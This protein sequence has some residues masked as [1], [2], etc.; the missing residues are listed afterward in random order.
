MLVKK[1]FRIPLLAALLCFWVILSFIFVHSD[2]D[3]FKPKLS[4]LVSHA[5]AL[6]TDERSYNSV[7]SAFSGKP[8]S[9]PHDWFNQGLDTTVVWYRAKFLT[10]KTNEEP[11]AVYLP[12]VTH[13]AEIYINGT[14]IGHSS[15][16]A[17]PIPRHHNYPILLEF[18]SELLKAENEIV[19]RVE[20]AHARQGLLGEFFVAPSSQL[21]ESY[22]SKNIWR[23][24]LIKW[25]TA[26]MLF[27]AFIIL[28]F[29]L[30]RP[31]D[32]IYGL[33][34]LML[35][36]W[37]AHNLNLFVIHI[38]V[39][40]HFWESMTMATL[41][42]TVVL[43][44]HFNHR[45][46]GEPVAVIEK[47]AVI[48]AIAGLG[49]FLIP[50]LGM[51]LHFG[52]LVWDGF[53][54][55]FGIYALLYLGYKFYQKLELD[56]YLMLVA[57]IP[58]LVFGLHDILVVNHLRSRTE[59]LIIQYSVLP[60][61][62]LFTWF[63][64][65][66]FVES[67][68]EAEQLNENLETRVKTKQQEIESQYKKLMELENKQTLSHERDRIMRDMHDGIGGQL[69]S[70]KDI[71]ARQPEQPTL[72]KEKVNACLID[73]RTVIDSLDPALSDIAT[74]LGNLRSRLERQL[75]GTGIQLIWSINELPD[76]FELKPQQSLHLMRII[77]EAVNNAIKHTETPSIELE[78]DVDRDTRAFEIA[79]KDKGSKLA[80]AA[81]QGRGINNMKY[82]SQQL[83]AQC[84]VTIQPE[85][86]E[87][88]LRF[89][90]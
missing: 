37:S 72:I 89:I 83:G 13:N 1:T 32:K 90:T 9:L 5:E 54:I 58:I 8:I 63:L 25:M 44:I 56:I 69:I 79:I 3:L 67:L 68:N 78:A 46:V 18:T 31:K 40:T 52:Y 42:W 75:E 74:L 11:W 22:Q 26:I 57:G 10:D 47:A 88:R 62:G 6:I 4:G 64:I 77:Q 14:W 66:R 17:N 85:G 7:K 51:V 2:R 34:S 20:A 84:E 53:L 73:L 33:F 60:A 19:L 28:W 24:E 59:G 49:I 16:P 76:L 43:M 15:A 41:G 87:V 82:R 23:I 35:F 80:K 48:F 38:P 55:V 45:Y 12:A 36:I 70:L 61:M 39:P 71:L 50:D 27:T 21:M 86:S 81:N 65:R 30:Y 29:W